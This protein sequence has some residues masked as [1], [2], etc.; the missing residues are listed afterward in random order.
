MTET[1]DKRGLAAALSLKQENNAI[2]AGRGTRNSEAAVFQATS[3]N[4]GVTKV[5]KG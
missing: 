4:V 2:G 5:L 3:G 1:T